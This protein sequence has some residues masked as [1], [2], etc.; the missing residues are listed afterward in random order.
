[1]RNVGSEASSSASVALDSARSGSLREN[2]VI[3]GNG[4]AASTSAEMMH[5]H[6]QTQRNAHIS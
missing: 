5:A 6:A 4:T 3:D 2:P 1:M